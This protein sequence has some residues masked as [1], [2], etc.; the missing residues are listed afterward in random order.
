MAP[1]LSQDMVL[2]LGPWEP[3]QAT[4]SQGREVFVWVW[5]LAEAP[6]G[7]PQRGKFHKAP[8]IPLNLIVLQEPFYL[9]FT[10]RLIGPSDSQRDPEVI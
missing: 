5:F 10:L 9:G 1:L 2:I 6:N 7:F 8:H 3:G 4:P